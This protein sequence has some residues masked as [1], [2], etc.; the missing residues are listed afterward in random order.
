MA[1]RFAIKDIKEAQ[2]YL[3]HDVLGPR[4][5]RSVEAVM[6]HAGSLTAHVIFGTPDDLKFR[7]SMT[8][9]AAANP[10]E[11]HFYDAIDRFYGGVEDPETL[12]RLSI[13]ASSQ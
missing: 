2:A 8:L 13:S 5:R 10:D 7:S 6:P 12:K 9:F 3:A 1:Q 4:L 11:P